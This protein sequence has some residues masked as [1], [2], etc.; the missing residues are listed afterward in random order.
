MM[1]YREKD[2][3]I[4]SS[5]DQLSDC[6]LLKKYPFPWLQL[7]A[8]KLATTVFSGPSVAMIGVGQT[9]LTV[10]NL[11]TCEGAELAWLIIQQA[12]VADHINTEFQ[13]LYRNNV[14]AT[15]NICKRMRRKI[16]GGGRKL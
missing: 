14:N 1:D 16:V 4:S 8:A 7:F 11:D 5:L 13:Q 2:N 6:Q 15:F 10:C 9:A 12:A 3:N